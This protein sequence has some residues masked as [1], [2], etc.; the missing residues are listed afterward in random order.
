MGLGVLGSRDLGILGGWRR[1]RD[2]GY[3]GSEVW[4]FANICLVIGEGMG[5]GVRGFG[6]HGV[7]DD[8]HL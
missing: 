2:G 6:I 1:G 4:I 8:E 7:K 3:L 5:D